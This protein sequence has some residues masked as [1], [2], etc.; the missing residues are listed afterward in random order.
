MVGWP[1]KLSVFW[2]NLSASVFFFYQQKIGKKKPKLLLGIYALW[3]W[4]CSVGVTFLASILQDHD[5]AY[6]DIWNSWTSFLGMSVTLPYVLSSWQRETKLG[7]SPLLFCIYSSLTFQ[8]YCVGCISG[9]C[10]RTKSCGIM[11]ACSIIL[12]DKRWWSQVSHL[13][14]M[15]WFQYISEH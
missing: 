2:V 8:N 6:P 10:N 12:F 15:L 3:I 11:R 13:Y 14:W 4:N 1:L 7:F 9:F 5:A